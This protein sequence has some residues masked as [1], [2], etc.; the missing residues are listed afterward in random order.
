M[1][2]QSNHRLPTPCPIGNPWIQYL[3]SYYADH[4]DGPFVNVHICIVSWP[5]RQL[6]WARSY[7]NDAATRFQRHL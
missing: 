3:H 4:Q 5:E 2:Q 6:W 1:N 7:I